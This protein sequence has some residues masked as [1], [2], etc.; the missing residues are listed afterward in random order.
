MHYDVHPIIKSM[1]T[2]RIKELFKM[3]K[4]IFLLSTTLKKL[5][6]SL[7]FSNRTPS[8]FT[9]IEFAVYSEHS[10]NSFIHFISL[11]KNKIEHKLLYTLYVY[12]SKAD[13]CYYAV[14]SCKFTV[15][16]QY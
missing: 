6:P 4:N 5:A 1:L 14:K 16:D 2:N 7:F 8:F 10:D 3:H 15:N 11:V 13:N 12:K 9:K